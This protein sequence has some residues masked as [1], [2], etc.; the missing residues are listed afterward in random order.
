MTGLNVVEVRGRFHRGTLVGSPA[1]RDVWHHVARIDPQAL[2]TQ[3]PQWMD[4]MVETGVWSDASRW[5]VAADGRDL[6]LPIARRRAIGLRG[7]QSSF[8]EGWG[9]GGLLSS[10]PLKPS[11]VGLV[12]ADLRGERALRTTIRINPLLADPWRRAAD[13]GIIIKPRSAH[14]LDLGGGADEVWDHRMTSQ[15]RRGVRRAGKLG[16]TVECDTEGRLLGVFYDMLRQSFER[17]AAMQHEPRWM[18]RLRGALRDPLRKFEILAD[19]LGSG[20]R[21]YVARLEGRPA[22]ALVVLMGGNAHYTRGAMDAEVGGRSNANDLL[23]WTAI[24]DA[25]EAGCPAYHMGETAP[26]SS[27]ARYKEKLGARLVPYAEYVVERHPIT[28]LDD[29]IRGAVKRMI[30]F[31]DA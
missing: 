29:G 12:L 4:A 14:V 27:L 24:R 21:L 28:R 5:Y 16:V 25:C 31:R 23:H 26:G 7:F 8:A 13:D 9:M 30:G 20:F 3:T 11:D 22:A 19:R 1:P 6:V 17:W 15:G 2:V 18:A 10:G